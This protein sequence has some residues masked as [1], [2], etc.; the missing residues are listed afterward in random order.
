M[1]NFPT[2]APGF[3]LTVP[4]DQLGPAGG[5]R[6][7]LP[8]R[9]TTAYFDPPT[10][11][12][13]LSRAPAGQIGLSDG[14]RSG[15]RLSMFSN[16]PVSTAFSAWGVGGA[17]LALTREVNRNALDAVAVDR[18]TVIEAENPGGLGLAVGQEWFEKC[19]VIPG[20]I[21]LG[22]V[23]SIQVRTIELFNAF[24]RPLETITWTAFVN[25]T[26]GGITVTNLPLLPFVIEAFASFIVDVTIST[27]GPPSISGTLDFTLSAP[28]AATISVPITGNRITIFQYRPQTPIRETL[29][30]KTD[31]IRLFDG[32][33]QRIKLR[34]APRQ[35]FDFKVRTDDD[36]TRDS[37]NAVLFD[38]QA[39]VFGVPVW[40]ESEPLDAP[41]AIN[42]LVIQVDTTTSDYRVDSLVMVYDGNFNFLALEVESFTASSITVKTAFTQAFDTLSTLIMPIRTA[43]TKP[44]LQNTRFAIGPS[45]FSM[46]FD[47]L[48]NVDLSDIGAVTTHLG[49]GQT[50]SK[51]VLDGFNFMSGNTIGEGIRRKTIELDHQT[52]PK[53]TLSPWAKGKPTYQFATEAKS[54]LEVWNFRKLMH[55]LKGSQTAFY[56]PTGR[57]DFKPL[58]DIGDSAT[59]FQIP[60]IGWTD[61][62][63]SVTPRSDLIIIRT[64]GTQSLHLITG[65]TV[66]SPDIETIT[67]SPPISPA[68]PLAELDRMAVMTLS[69]IIDDKVTLEHRRP[70]ESRLSIKSIGIPS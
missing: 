11:A 9:G 20:S 21:A 49:V 24:R 8:S 56:I 19:H 68:L 67:I 40:H 29:A 60:N 69:R 10:N 62:V 57:R 55:F 25:N 53:I 6:L 26:G 12:V 64:D 2:L 7:L 32:T 3:P 37:I 23:L 33:E 66:G 22:N 31:V 4:N 43:Y 65:S 50:I 14:S 46:T 13:P 28:T 48:D 59:G 16:S 15:Q 51:P 18:Q 17:G 45:D 54:Q 5:L 47:V 61:F 52:G 1:A 42:D 63:Q 38:W 44:S 58:A 39:R 35:A 36:R 41:I 27:S 30:F 34:E 70:G